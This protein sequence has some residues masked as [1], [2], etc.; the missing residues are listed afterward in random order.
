MKKLI[1]FG[2]TALACA[3]G[4]YLYQKWMNKNNG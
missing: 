2:A 3:V 4:V 1:G